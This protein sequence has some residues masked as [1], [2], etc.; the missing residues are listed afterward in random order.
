MKN[1]LKRIFSKEPKHCMGLKGPDI[2]D[3]R[4]ILKVP[5]DGEEVRPVNLAKEYKI[6]VR[7]QRQT[8]ACS[9]YAGAIGLEILA[10]KLSEKSRA[11][12]NIDLSALEIYWQARLDKKKDDGAFMRD[13]M[14]GMCKAGGVELRFWTDIDSVLHRPKNLDYAT[15]FKI[16]STYQR[17]LVGTNKTVEDC[18]KVLSVERL[19]IWIG[20]QMHE[21]ET[22]KA[23]QGRVYDVPSSRDKPTGGHA[24]TI[25]GWKYDPRDSKK[26][27]FI[28]Q[29]SWGD[30]WGQ[31]GFFLLSED[32]LSTWG[33]VFDLW[34]VGNEYY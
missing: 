15:R 19:P 32:V 3:D 10:N 17:I 33:Y 12:W 20:M 22:R 7:D 18:L 13:L 34:T 21:L 5:F 6:K 4:D 14:N 29:N 30:R 9:G 8:N 11:N 23:G 1:L 25:V 26:K 24:M 16:R 2:K 31:R 27:V 28:V